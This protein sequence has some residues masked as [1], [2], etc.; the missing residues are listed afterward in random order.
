M[1]LSHFELEKNSADMQIQFINQLLF[2]L[3]SRYEQSARHLIDELKGSYELQL[4]FPHG[5]AGHYEIVESK[6]I[7]KDPA[8][9]SLLVM[10]SDGMHIPFADLMTDVQDLLISHLHIQHNTDRLM[11]NFMS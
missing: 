10:S 9:D 7:Y 11:N 1:D 6:R 3:R 8:T 4:S 5:S 2:E